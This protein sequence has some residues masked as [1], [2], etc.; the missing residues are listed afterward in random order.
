MDEHE[1]I[2]VRVRDWLADGWDWDRIG[3]ALGMDEDEAYRQ[4]GAEASADLPEG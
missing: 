2:V 1:K 3:V 4:F